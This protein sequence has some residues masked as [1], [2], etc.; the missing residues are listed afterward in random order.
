[1]QKHNIYQ[2]PIAILNNSIVDPNIEFA[3]QLKNRNLKPIKM[4]VATK[5]PNYI[6]PIF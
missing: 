1:M 4:M 2:N 3:I 5:P 6:Q